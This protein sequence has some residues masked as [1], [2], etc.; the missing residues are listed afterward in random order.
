MPRES[1][2]AHAARSRCAFLA[3]GRGSPHRSSPSRNPLTTHT[4]RYPRQRRR[5][6]APMTTE[7][8]DPVIERLRAAAPARELDPA[9]PRLEPVTAVRR[10][11]ASRNT[12]RMGGLATLLAACATLALVLP[13]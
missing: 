1:A 9:L 4:P 13:G 12:A 5:W 7:C 3:H 8:P 6:R 2:A 11:R 10:R